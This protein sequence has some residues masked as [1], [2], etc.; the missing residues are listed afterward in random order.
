MRK[1]Y[2]VFV[3]ALGMVSAAQIHLPPEG[4][5]SNPRNTQRGQYQ[6][7]IPKNGTITTRVAAIVSNFNL[8][9]FRSI[10]YGFFC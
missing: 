9:A 8:S 10:N 6:V 1:M 3:L 4:G 5:P 7:V 2:L